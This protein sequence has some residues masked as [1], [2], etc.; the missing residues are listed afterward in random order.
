MDCKTNEFLDKEL[1]I[2]HKKMFHLV[3]ISYLQEV[4]KKVHK[5]V[6][7]GVAASREKTSSWIKCI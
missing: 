6:K 2:V 5:N 1:S 4:M 3:F 7:S